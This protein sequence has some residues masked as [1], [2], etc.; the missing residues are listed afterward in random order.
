[1]DWS[2]NFLNDEILEIKTSGIFSIDDLTEMIEQVVVDPKWKP[3]MNII[4]D[5]REID[6]KGV[7]VTEIYKVKNLHVQ[8]NDI[9]GEGKIAIILNSNL[10]YGFS[11]IY[12]AISS[13]QV[14][15]KIMTFRD[16]DSGVEWIQGK[17]EMEI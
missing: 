15:S 11:R 7:N 14:K 17:L 16:Y 6:V 1:M 2:L 3:G 9:A 10:A 12:Q 5:F 13:T 4:A 8:Y